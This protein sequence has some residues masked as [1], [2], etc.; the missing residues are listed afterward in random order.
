MAPITIKIKTSNEAAFPVTIDTDA[1]VADLKAEIQKVSPAEGGTPPRLIFAGKVLKDEETLQ[2]YKV[3]DGNTI[4]MV[5]A[6]V[7]STP[8]ASSSAPTTA[9]ETTSTPATPST[10][11][12]TTSTP[13]AAAP[14]PNP[15][16]ALGGGNGAAN[17]FAALAGLGAG[18]GAG[19]G[20]GS[21]FGG[22]FP[23][24]DP[25][26]INQLMSNPAVADSVAGLFSNPQFLDSMIASNPQ[27]ASMMTPQMRQMMSNPDMMRAMMQMMPL[28][29][30][31]NGPGMGLG[32]MGAGANPFAPLG[33]PTTGTA[34]TPTS[35]TP[36]ANAGA[37]PLFNPALLSMLSGGGFGGLGGAG[38]AGAAS[39]Q[40]PEERFQVQLQQLQDM[41]FYDASENVRALTL[42]GGNVEA[43][44]E[45]LF[46]NPPGGQR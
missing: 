17:P 39:T 5:R 33:V 27:L 8:A 16:A 42:T 10:A 22:G 19:A 28:M 18:A 11:S 15:F 36:G 34:G 26:M 14:L 46:A 7:R 21:P 31:L 43:A 41:G 45:W 40:P 32:G 24:V 29:G 35:G 30:G 6:A 1:T 2:I 44:V 25:A 20:A 37:N 4:H 9:T 38:G 13:A 3:A 23:A 12:T